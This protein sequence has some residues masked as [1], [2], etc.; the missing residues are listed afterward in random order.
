MEKI[1]LIESNQSIAKIIKEKIIDVFDFTVDI[2]HSKNE[3]KDKIKDNSYLLSIVSYNILNEQKGD[4]VNFIL[5]ENIPTIVLVNKL[6]K[7]MLKTLNNM[8][9]IDYIIK[10]KIDDIL[11]IIHTIERIYKN[12]HYKALVI[13]DSNIYRKHI[14]SLLQDQLIVTIDLDDPMQVGNILLKDDSIKLL[15]VDYELNGINGINL[16][17]KIRY[18]HHKDEL[19]IVAINSSK[20]NLSSQFLKYGANDYMI[21]DFTKEEFN[22]RINNL[23]E[24]FENI[25]KMK[26]FAFKDYLTGL[27]NRRYFFKIIDE[28]LLEKNIKS[29]KIPLS[30]SMIDIDNFKN[31]NDTYGHDI[32]DQAIK[33]LSKVLKDNTKNSDVVSRFGGEEFCLV[34]KNINKDDNLMLLEK[35]RKSIENNILEI[36]NHKFSFTVSI[37]T[38]HIL[39]KSS[40]NDINNEIK[41][42]DNR[43]YIAKTTGKN[44]V[45]SEDIS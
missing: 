23:I 6:N 19:I 45:I 33:F 17:E 25:E 18:T 16:I 30:I 24:S 12:K 27:Y 28:W 36:N 42:A 32:G 20:K 37:G 13:G 7:K 21:N 5:S 29:D 1:L 39:D 44:K 15:I 40:I 26:E 38:K 2:V 41:I 3:A 34:L 31:I 8:H 11:Y 35:I 9:I 4:A 14:K 10:D 22:S 43:L